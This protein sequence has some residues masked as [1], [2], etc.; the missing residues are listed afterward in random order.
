MLDGQFTLGVEE[1]FQIVDPETRELKSY[2]SRILEDGKAILEERIKP[3][4]H[5][6]VVETGT[7]ICKDVKD[8]R[9][10]VVELRSAISQLA[11]KN[12]L[13]I[14]AASTHPISDWKVQ[15][16]TE[17]DRYKVLVDD[18]QDV[19]RGNLIWG[20]HVHV[21][22]KDK[23]VAVA[24]TNQVR[25]FL[26]HILA[27][28]TSSPFWIGRKTGLKSTRCEVFKQFPRTGIPDYFFSWSDFDSYVNLLIKTGCIDN[29]KKIWWDVRPHPFFETVEVRICDI[30]TRLDDT[31]AIAALIQ[32]LMVKLYTIYRQ[33]MAWRNYSRALIEENKWRAVRYGLDGKLIDFGKRAEVDTKALIGEL[34]EFVDDA[35]D[36]CG[37][38][39]EIKG[40]H[41]ILD[42]G[43]SADRQLKIYEE[44]GGDMKAVVD[45]L[46][47]ETVAGLPKEGVSVPAAQAR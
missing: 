21:G 45:H 40:I 12:G 23:D 39:E 34:L 33:N 6:S 22:I 41:R 32:A 1:E 17:H 19:A 2:I 9:R 46:I 27:L 24:L 30:P 44:S 14:I 35:V 5:Q 3:E 10:E 28:S 15:D 47:A 37:S 7:G 26:P 42:H 8:V 20:L 4:M 11:Q 16:I 18:L 38:R 25:Y 13:R 31:V 29:G 43:T 36:A